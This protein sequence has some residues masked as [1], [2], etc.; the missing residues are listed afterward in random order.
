MTNR[1]D[2]RAESQR[3]AHINNTPATAA[4]DRRVRLGQM[5]PTFPRARGV[6]VAVSDQGQVRMGL[7]SPMFPPARSK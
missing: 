5:G 4:D 2:R 3:L 6:P 7:M 1:Q